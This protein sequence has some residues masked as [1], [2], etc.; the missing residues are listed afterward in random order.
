MRWKDGERAGQNDKETD[1]DL[2][3]GRKRHR[4]KTEKLRE[5][6]AIQRDREKDRM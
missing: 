6:D 4:D 3:R 5:K 2:E 1:G